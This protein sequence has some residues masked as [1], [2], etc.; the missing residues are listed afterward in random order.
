MTPERWRLRLRLSL[1][2]VSGGALLL[3]YAPVDVRWAAFVALVPLALALRSA[4]GR[5]GAAC[6]FVFGVAFFGPLV[7]WIATFGW[8]AWGAL[9][10]SQAAATALFGWFAAW[11]G[12]RVTGRVLAWPLLYAGVEM[13]RARWPLGGFAWG[14]LGTSQHSGLPLLPLARLGGVFA[15]SGALVAVNVLAAEAVARGHVVKRAA[16]F[17][18]AIGVAIAPAWQPLGI[19][20]EVG[21]LDVA[22]VQGS[23]PRGTFTGGRGQRIGP[24][25]KVILA[26]HVRLTETLV[27]DPPDVVIWPENVLDRDPFSN[28]DVMEEVQRVVGLVDRRLIVG[29]ILDAPG[30]RFRNANLLF[31]PD[32]TLAGRY[33][34]VHLVPFGEYVPWP[35]LRR[36]IG[37]LEQVPL[38]GVAGPRPVVLEWGIGRIGAVVCFE[39]TYPDLV[40]DFVRA[41][42][43]VVVVSTNNASFGD[44]P[45]A[46]QHLAQSQMRAVEEGR[47]VVHAAISGISAVIAPDGE[48]V[49]EAGLFRAAVLRQ[50]VPLA[51]GMTPYA[52][53]GDVTELAIGGGAG[54]AA[55]L[56]AAAAGRRR[57]EPR[58]REEEDEDEFWQPVAPGS[59]SGPLLVS[60]A[61][62]NEHPD[63]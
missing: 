13:L 37:A 16:A 39:S 50:T 47:A 31:A 62:G 20:R 55:L 3:A 61:P 58:A 12:R 54:L 6:G 41:G 45:A 42:A 43:Q 7:G 26:N 19:T 44:S 59:T 23:V 2:A 9:V 53:F 17:A 57:R 25:D 21:T 15:V 18:A 63:G 27:S 32:G 52:R 38:D 35:W 22:V 36:A 30:R 1:A 33:D 40:R 5:A 8:L 60:D 10:G 4:S 29:A 49:R 56:G 24:E 28:P 14:L 46:R 51:D 34:K 11:T 48:I